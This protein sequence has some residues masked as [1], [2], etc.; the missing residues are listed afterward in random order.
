MRKIHVVFISFRK[1]A[2]TYSKIFRDQPQSP[3]ER[4]VFWVEYVLRNGYNTT[5]LR[6]PGQDMTVFY[7]MIPDAV[8]AFSV[9][10]VI[11]MIKSV[12]FSSKE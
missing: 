5:V 1:N 6:S 8:I 11:V 9:I 2:E 7:Q 10:V 4:A 12:F 3:L